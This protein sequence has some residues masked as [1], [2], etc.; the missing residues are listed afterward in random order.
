MGMTVNLTDSVARYSFEFQI[1][2]QIACQ[3][4]CWN[5]CKFECKYLYEIKCED[6]CGIKVT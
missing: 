4:A 2:W 5:T 3:I 1:N 6:M